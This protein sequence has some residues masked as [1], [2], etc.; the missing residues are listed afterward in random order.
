M[1]P[2]IARWNRRSLDPFIDSIP[3]RGA[4]AGELNYI[5]TRILLRWLREGFAGYAERALAVGV[6]ETAKLE[7]YRR[8]LG[9][10]E[11]S[12]RDAHG[13]VYGQAEEDSPRGVSSWAEVPRDAPAH[14]PEV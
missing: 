3:V 12:K 2:Y 10:Y 6:L 4:T 11:D 13:D 8:S 7:F 1:S 9:P 14:E 5:I